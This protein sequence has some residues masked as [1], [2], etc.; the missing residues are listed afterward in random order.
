MA[1]VI[2]YPTR[3]NL[4]KTLLGLWLMMGIAILTAA[5]L[6]DPKADIWQEI[7][8]SMSV[9]MGIALILIFAYSRI[10]PLGLMRL[11]RPKAFERHLAQ[12]L[13]VAD[14]LGQLDQDT[15]VFHGFVFELF[16]VE[17]L[18][19]STQ[20]VFVIA[21]IRESHAISE[22]DG[23]LYSGKK[24]LETLTGSTWRICHLISIVMKKYFHSDMMP[25]PVL[26]TP[27]SCPATINKSGGITILSENSLTEFIETR[28]SHME[29]DT[30][31]SFASFLRKRYAT[32]V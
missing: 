10:N 1:H 17:H 9:G 31:I 29:K 7:F 16:R 26:V 11:I 19:V 14:A 24:S 30:V 28:D 8:S 13:I 27:E 6:F 4:K 3:K 5:L 23:V 21:K 2:G 12:D 20:G 25:M 32:H 18:V 15:H 22:Q